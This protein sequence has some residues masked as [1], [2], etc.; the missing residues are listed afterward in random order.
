MRM[1]ALRLSI[2]LFL[3]IL[4]VLGTFGRAHASLG[5]CRTDPTVAF[6]TVD[7]SRHTALLSAGIALNSNQV[8]AVT[9]TVQLPSG[10]TFDR[11]ASNGNVA[12]TVNVTTSGPAGII[13]ASA[14]VSSPSNAS[15][16]VDARFG[17]NPH[18]PSISA[19][20][21]TN[22]TITVSATF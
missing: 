2:A 6:T 4:T 22:T 5:F 9:W 18:N 17:H 1:W 8:D 3:V 10:S 14:V 13:T 12:E 7:G 16:I 20:G 15:V 21:T 11:A 19:Q